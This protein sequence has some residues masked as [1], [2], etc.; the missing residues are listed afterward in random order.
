MIQL[1]LEIR[2]GIRGDEGLPLFNCWFVL[3]KTEALEVMAGFVC[4]FK[5]GE[6]LDVK[7]VKIAL[8]VGDDAEDWLPEDEREECADELVH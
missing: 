7:S 2:V 5:C 8:V 3:E 1:A 6:S 4:A